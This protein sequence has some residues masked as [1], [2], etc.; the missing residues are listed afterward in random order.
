M[1]PPAR[2][3][4]L[5]SRC[6]ALSAACAASSQRPREC[7]DSAR[8]P[9]TQPSESGRPSLRVTWTPSS[10]SRTASSERPTPSRTDG[11]FTWAR[12]ATMSTHSSIARSLTSY[13]SASPASMSPASTMRPPRVRRALSSMSWAP[14]MRAYST[15]LSAAVM[16]SG[17]GSWSI[18]QL[19]AA[20]RTSA[21]TSEGGSPRTRSCAVPSSAQP[22]PRARAWVSRERCT[23]NQAARSGSGSSSRRRRA[24]LVIFI[25][26]SRSPQRR[27]A[28]A[29]SAIRSR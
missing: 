2:G 25:E 7:R 21:C 22:S 27:P 19:A 6:C 14:T 26:R 24:R 16:A 12:A 13:I 10:R 17:P 1:E 15:A 18:D 4:A 5:C 8:L 28:T 20:A 3:L 29:A 11:R 23:Q 9:H